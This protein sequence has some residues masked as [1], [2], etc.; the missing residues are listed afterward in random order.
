M[1]LL[2]RFAARLQVVDELDVDGRNAMVGGRVTYSSL[3][4]MKECIA[5]LTSCCCS[6]TLPSITQTSSSSMI[7]RV[8]CGLDGRDVI[9]ERLGRIV[10]QALM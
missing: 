1:R 6:Y 2:D 3:A 7:G 9:D 10:V 8:G 4:L 5:S